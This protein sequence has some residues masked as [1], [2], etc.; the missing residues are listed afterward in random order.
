M[1]NPVTMPLP[2]GWSRKAVKRLQGRTE[3]KFDIYVYSPDGKKFR[4]KNE[5]RNYLEKNSIKDID[6][7]GFDF[8]CNNTFT[9]LSEEFLSKAT[10]VKKLT[11][12]PSAKK[13][14]SIIKK[15]VGNSKNNYAAQFVDCFS[16][17]N[18]SSQS[19]NLPKHSASN[20]LLC[21]VKVVN[22][23]CTVTNK[24]GLYNLNIRPKS[25][26]QSSDS[27][28]DGVEALPDT[29]T[30]KA[31]IVPRNNLV[32]Y[33][34]V[35][36]QDTQLEG[37]CRMD[38]SDTFKKHC[39]LRDNIVQQNKYVTFLKSAKSIHVPSETFSEE[40][41][42]SDQ[43]SNIQT[44]CV[45]NSTVATGSTCD[46]NLLDIK[47]N[48]SFCE[49]YSNTS[50]DINSKSPNANSSTD[51]DIDPI[52]DTLEKVVAEMSFD[53]SDMADIMGASNGYLNCST[54]EM[55]KLGTIV[56]N[57]SNEASASIRTQ[58]HNSSE[59]EW[60]DMVEAVENSSDSYSNSSLKSINSALKKQDTQRAIVQAAESQTRSKRHQQSPYFKR[61]TK[62][63]KS[64]YF[65]SVETPSAKEIMNSVKW[66]PPKS[67]YNLIQES[68]YDD[69]WKLL[70]ATIFLNKTSG[71]TAIPLVWK[72][73]ERWPT[74]EA[75]YTA[76]KSELAQFMK[77]MGLHNR[78]AEQISRFSYEY[79]HKSWLYPK[80]LHGINKY[81]NDSFRIFCR[82]EW[83]KVKPLDHKL[84]V[85][86][87]WL[88]QNWKALGV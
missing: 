1:E 82:N 81:G 21:N 75:A 74:P 43:V 65:N 12:S 18:T 67:P 24:S 59:I 86:H 39:L 80:E 77:P 56:S 68:L 55:P 41:K 42:C 4:S 9:Y 6:P 23:E 54:N 15:K 66:V 16:L 3:G 37:T 27:T 45:Q 17:K 38:T 78:R 47:P 71:K 40:R 64:K 49:D 52:H 31:N 8:S 7:D 85:Y 44:I 26:E 29:R 36:T 84:N 48:V 57:E 70:I 51:V 79:R 30:I 22:S 35:K 2:K 11:K 19:L 61:S 63:V 14:T 5:I 58:L 28:K 69:P 76:D 50:K 25:L 62:L 72:F 34:V 60:A 88:C 33:I 83:R 53:S 32:N 10:R 13:T 46:G 73:F 20:L 87:N